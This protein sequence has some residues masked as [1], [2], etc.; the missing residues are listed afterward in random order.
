MEAHFMLSKEKKV[1]NIPKELVQLIPGF[2]SRRD[3]DLKNMKVFYE[4]KN[5]EEI[6]K[7][8]HRLKGNGLGYGFDY[9]SVLGKEI[10]SSSL[11]K[12]EEKLN[13]SLAE[14]EE[15]LKYVKTQVS[16]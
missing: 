10:E 2:L 15:Y 16:Y 6:R 9:L 11:S 13:E 1:I 3:N 5:F 7:V 14:L 4:E 8:G 12:D